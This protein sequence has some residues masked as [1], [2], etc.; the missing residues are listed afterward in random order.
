ME[1]KKTPIGLIIFL[2]I[3][4]LLLGGY[5]V[6]DKTVLSK[7][8][9]SNKTSIDDVSIDLNVLYRIGDTLDKFDSAFNDSNSE[10]F[11]YLYKS[12]KLLASKF[13]NGAALFATI[14]DDLVG[15][16][17]AQYLVGAKVK[18]K[19][20]KIF[21]KNLTYQPTSIKA[22]TYYNIIYNESNSTFAY[23]APTVTNVYPSEYVTINTKTKIEDDKVLVT[24]KTF[25]VEYKSNDGGT[26]ITKANIYTNLDKNKLVGEINLRNNVLN[27]D[28][29]LAKYGS[30]FNEYL[31]TFKQ[32][33]NNEDY[34]FYSLE[35]VK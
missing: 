22:G 35:K 5:I 30:R 17:T 7:T 3:L 1:D 32:N 31:F 21:G 11:G 27:E 19:F 20:E 15:T 18:N 25:F 13:D 33:T 34:A 29:V 4:I 10:Y 24:R 16:N 26:D 6:L 2:L 8:D 9:T 23:T 28:E 14:H 12:D